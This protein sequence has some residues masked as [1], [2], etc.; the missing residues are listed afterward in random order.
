[1]KLKYFPQVLLVVMV[2]ICSTLSAWAT[3]TT[4]A[5]NLVSSTHTVSQTSTATTISFS[6]TKAVSSF[7][8]NASIRYEYVL[9]TDTGADNATT[10]QGYL[11]TASETGLLKRGTL[12]NSTTV[13]ASSL[14]DGSFYV[15]L[16]SVDDSGVVGTTI[17]K[18]GPYIINTTPTLDSSTPITP[19]SGAHQ[20]AISVTINGGNFMS[21]ATVQLVNGKRTS[22]GSTI[23]LSTVTLTNVVLVSA[24]QLTAT[25]P[26]ST[27]PGVYDIQVTNSNTKSVS[28]VGKYTSTN[29]APVA[30]PGSAATVNLDNSGSVSVSLSGSGTDADSGDTI[31]TYTWTLTSMPTGANITSGGAAMASNSTMS[32]AS[33]TVVIRTQ[34]QYVFSLVVN[35]GYDSSAA[36]TKTVTVNA[37]AGTNTAP[38]ANPGSDSTVAPATEVTLNGGNSSDVDGNTLTYTWNLTSKPTGSTLSTGI[39]SITKSTTNPALATF[40]PDKKGTYVVSLV[41]NDGTVDS[42]AK[43]V[44]VTANNAPVANAGS[45]Q[46]VA[47]GATVTL[48]GSGSTDADNTQATPNVDTLTYA[49][50][51]TSPTTPVVTLSDAA[52]QKPTFTPTASGTYTFRLV[53]ND[54]TQNSTNTAT[55]TITVHNKPVAS[56]ASSQIFVAPG[57]AVT[58]DGST[59][60]VGATGGTLTYAWTQ[61]SGPSTITLSS[62]TVPKPTFTAPT[63]LG[64]WVFSLTV[65]D[66]YNSS[67]TPATVTVVTNNK[68]VVSAGDAKTVTTAGSIALTGTATDADSQTM[69]YAWTVESQPTGSSITLTN[70]NALNASFTPTVSGAYT[71]KLTVSDGKESVTSTVTVTYSNMP[72]DVDR[73]GSVTATDGL[74]IQRRLTGGDIIIDGVGLPTEQN[75]TIRGRIDALGTLLDVD[76]NGSVGATDGLLIQRR[77]TGGD[78]IID[79]VGLPSEQNDT[80]RGRIDALK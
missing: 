54:G 79:G 9:T 56:V 26:A 62:A 17:G 39:S 66:G 51:Q 33:Q 18:S 3:I 70:A 32:G 48:D 6:W 4:G 76:Q 45:A 23:N 58:L 30:V 31:S 77:L 34:G 61:T 24:T 7:G 78:I 16:R 64:T 19:A 5:T 43:S 46:T 59:S 63:T 28:A 38:V 68:P 13:S 10:F 52:A 14:S 74:L 57:G 53:V 65:N 55:V 21:G 8:T 12:T 35:D 69:T 11:D 22:G 1:M 71:F 41:V 2:W 42:A 29:T 80:I 36:V 49:W 15:Y 50:T 40:T 67:A 25:V 20:S 73:D 47:V 44:T 37:A 27:A 72:L 75:D 60:T